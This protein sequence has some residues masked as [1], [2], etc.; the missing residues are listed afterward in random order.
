LAIG[1][2]A[3]VPSSAGRLLDQMGIP[4]EERDFAALSDTQWFERLAG[5]GFRIA[6][7]VGVFPRLELPQESEA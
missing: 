4:A 1:V 5:T 7:P 2:S 3:V 6:Q